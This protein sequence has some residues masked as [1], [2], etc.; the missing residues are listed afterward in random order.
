MGSR[1]LDGSRNFSPL[2]VVALM[3]AA[4][5]IMYHLRRFTLLY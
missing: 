3:F 4:N 2:Y 1:K 5:V